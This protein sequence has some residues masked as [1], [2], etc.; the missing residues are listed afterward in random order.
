MPIAFDLLEEG[1]IVRFTVSGQWSLHEA[2]AFSPRLVQH[3]NHAPH[4]VHLLVDLS[5]TDAVPAQILQLRKS[6]QFTHSNI[7]RIAYVG[8]L[9]Q[10]IFSET[11]HKLAHS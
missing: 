8:N 3:C 5:Q 7:H 2:L 4:P 6:V 10:R 11:I 9:T 1:H